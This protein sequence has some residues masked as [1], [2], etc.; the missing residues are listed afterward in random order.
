MLSSSWRMGY[1]TLK[2]VVD[3][4]LADVTLRVALSLLSCKQVQ[5]PF[6]KRSPYMT[7]PSIVA[8]QL[9]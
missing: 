3:I 6:S 7:T 9:P 5:L 2:D 8:L 4:S 1:A